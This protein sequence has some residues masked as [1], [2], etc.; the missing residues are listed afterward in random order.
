MKVIGIGGSLRKNSNS[1]YYV[2]YTLDRLAAEGMEAQ[3]ISLAGKAIK[4]CLGC[5]GCREAGK[6]TQ[7]DDDFE[8]IFE[9]M[10]QSDGIIVG[11][12][13]YYSSAA[14]QLMALLD[15]AGFS[16]RFSGRF[17]SRKVG[18]PITVARRAGHNLAF[19]QL[20]MWYYIN[21]MIIPGNTY[22]NV[23]TAGA[24]GAR[25]PENDRE[26]HDILDNFARN[27]AWLMKKIKSE[28]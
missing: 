25:D 15:R 4:P 9:K 6:C 27:M 11:S 26:A 17:F 24:G 8:Y 2:R 14:P 3:Y 13:V 5:Y 23:A 12:P 28:S 20:L 21:D 22:W 16:S 19:A 10:Y 18:A 7:G 1:E